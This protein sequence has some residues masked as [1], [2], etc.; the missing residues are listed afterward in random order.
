MRRARQRQVEKWQR[1]AVDSHVDHG[2]REDRFH[3]GMEAV[4]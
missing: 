4:R 1:L 2:R 3:V